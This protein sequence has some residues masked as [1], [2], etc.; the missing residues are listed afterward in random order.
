[1][2]S[3]TGS[4]EKTPTTISTKSRNLDW[5]SRGKTRDNPINKRRNIKARERTVGWKQKRNKLRNNQRKANQKTKRTNPRMSTK[6]EV[7][8]NRRSLR[9]QNQRKKN[10]HL[11]SRIHLNLSHL[12]LK[13]RSSIAKPNDWL[14]FIPINYITNMVSKASSVPFITLFALITLAAAQACSVAD[15]SIC[16]PNGQLCLVCKDNFFST[17]RGGCVGPS[18]KNCQAYVDSS[19]CI[20]CLPGNKLIDN[21]CKPVSSSCLEYLDAS[22][23]NKCFP[24]FTK[25]NKIC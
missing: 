5:N 1:M 13:S 8:V 11:T 10:E 19:I 4:T 24:E 15:C 7:F 23:C 20:K 12:R 22:T 2:K 25:V 17:I 3:G 14:V 9:R 18:I 16:T 6:R 21:T